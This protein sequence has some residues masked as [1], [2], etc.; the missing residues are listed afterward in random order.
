MIPPGTQFET[1]TPDQQYKIMV[2]FTPPTRRQT[3]QT[4]TGEMIINTDDPQEPTLR[5][6]LVARSI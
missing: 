4:E 2:T 1:L 6:Q 3:N 5:V